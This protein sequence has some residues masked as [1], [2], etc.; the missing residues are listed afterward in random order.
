MGVLRPR[1]GLHPVH[2]LHRAS[3]AAAGAFLIVFAL[4]GM[5]KGPTPLGGAGSWVF[6]MSSNG[7][8]SVLSL[9]VGVLLAAAAW[10]SGPMSSTISVVVGSLFLLSGVGNTLLLGTAENVLAFRV[11]N[12]VFSILFGF[13]LLVLGSYGRISGGLP[14]GNPYRNEDVHI[15]RPRGAVDSGAVSHASDRYEL[16]AAER[17][18]AL[19][20]ATPE[21]LRRL[22]VVHTYRTE[23]DRHRA[24]LS[25][26]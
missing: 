21:Q 4:V 12:I 23:D 22:A 25:S 13:T 9:L 24:W 7:L 19:R 18:F 20:R 17:A 5:S 3:A 10:R 15:P 26:R 16:A 8:L 11:P 6:G 1:S 2:T 14:H